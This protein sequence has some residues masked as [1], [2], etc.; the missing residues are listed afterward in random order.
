MNYHDFCA[1]CGGELTAGPHANAYTCEACGGAIDAFA[2]TAK[3]G[4]DGQKRQKTMENKAF[5]S[6]IAYRE[7]LAELP[8][9]C[10]ATPLINGEQEIEDGD[11]NQYYVSV[12]DKDQAK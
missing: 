2:D 9:P 8:D 4:N 10:S 7:W 1:Q 11:G 6:V 12:H 5:D 3:S